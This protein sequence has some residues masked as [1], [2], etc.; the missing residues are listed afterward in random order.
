MKGE[1]RKATV[2][3]GIG[4]AMA[5]MSTTAW[6]Q[7]TVDPTRPAVGFVLEDPEGAAGTQLQSVVIT[8]T[9]RAAIINGVVVEQGEKYGDAVLTRV[10]EDEVVLSSGGSR[11][12]L[13][14]HPGVEK[15]GM[16]RV[17]PVAPASGKSAPRKAKAKPET[18]AKPKAKAQSGA[19]P[20][21]AGSA[22][23][24]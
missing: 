15:V 24:R 16:T 17:E 18:R 5:A 1:R 19:K 13:K 6:A 20:A 4:I 8:P 9:R 7:I 21:A 3:M 23:A 22:G 11:Q 10:S 14:L 12:V 2:R